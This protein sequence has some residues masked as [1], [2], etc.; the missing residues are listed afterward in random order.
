MQFDSRFLYFNPMC[1]FL[2]GGMLEVEASLA[3]FSN[4]CLDS[5]ELRDTWISD[6]YCS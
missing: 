6:E 4:N 2:L 5:A 1:R 3:F